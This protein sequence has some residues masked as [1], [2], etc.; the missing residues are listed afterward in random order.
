MKHR[1]SFVAAVAL[2]A[3]LSAIAICAVPA[4]AG[5]AQIAQDVRAG[6]GMPAI[7]PPTDAAGFA[8]TAL[9]APRLRH[10]GRAA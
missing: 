2:S 7:A 10:S 9:A 8:P 3:A 1:L 6:P 4:G 5:T